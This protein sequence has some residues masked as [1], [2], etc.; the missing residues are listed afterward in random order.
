MDTE[1][2]SERNATAKPGHRLLACE[3]AAL[4]F[5]VITAPALLQQRKP[6][7]PLDEYVMRSIA[8]GLNTPGSIA[9]FLGLDEALVTRSLTRLWQADLIEV[10][11]GGAGRTL[12]LLAAGTRAVEELLEIAPEEVDVWFSFDRLLW[13]P[14]R[15]H[16]AQLLQPRD[17]REMDLLQVKPK[18][19]ARP[20]IDDLPVSQ[21]DPAVKA[22]MR[23]SLGEAD[24]LVVKR[25]DRAEQKFLPCHV[26]VYESLDGRDHALE[27]AIDG[28]IDGA[29]GAAVDALGG[30]EHLGLSFDSPVPQNAR[31]VAVVL[32]AVPTSI[33]PVMSLDEV[34]SLRRET[35]AASAAD[36]QVAEVQ[37][38]PSP[39]PTRPP[40][41]D[42]A[43]I[44]NIDTFEHPNYL[45]EACQSARRR[46]LVTSA[47]VRNA[48][49]NKSFMDGLYTL[50][51]RGVAIHIG[52]GI[53]MDAD[54]CD[55]AAMDR[56]NKLAERFPNVVVGCLGFTHAK[57]LIWD[58]SQITTSFNWLSFRGD[59]DRTYR[60]E[61]GILV[62]NHPTGVDSLY[63]SQKK[64]IETTAGKVVR[65][66]PHK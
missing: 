31:E 49:V 17:V 2:V 10:P 41:L 12:R 13:R 52:Y 55:E 65:S 40:A 19:L 7:P 21:V 9:G 4:P 48:V 22:S 18:K 30:S 29:I 26:L 56:L 61:L 60:Q 64:L 36:E 6:I 1:A 38:A 66:A 51:R 45:K 57:L 59:Q 16:P 39:L 3:P 34:D 47:W 46:L 62:K 42:A 43:Q 15:V 23:S 14:S 11:A 37:G 54:G 28:R 44:R 27:I 24:V 58:D 50:A 35:V 25:V 53:S 8:S 5:F 63:E 32:E 20:D 33:G